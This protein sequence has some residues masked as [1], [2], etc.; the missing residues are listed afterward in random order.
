VGQFHIAL[1]EPSHY[2]LALEL[3][4]RLC[5]EPAGDDLTGKM[6]LAWRAFHE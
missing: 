2:P 1:T 5:A 6:L 3:L 4:D